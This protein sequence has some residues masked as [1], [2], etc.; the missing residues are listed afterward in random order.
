[1]RGGGCAIAAPVFGAGGGIV[2]AIEIKTA[3]LGSDLPRLVPALG[4][5]HPSLSR[6]LAAS[7]PAVDAEATDATGADLADREPRL[8]RRVAAATT[9][10][11]SS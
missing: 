3:E 11:G 5:H 4:N 2:C 9:T 7:A 8:T 10:P 6:D 1:M